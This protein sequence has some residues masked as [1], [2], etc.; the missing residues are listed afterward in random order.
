MG[1]LTCVLNSLFN[2]KEI[3]G[4]NYKVVETRTG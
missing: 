2:Y 4:E 1:V 3:I